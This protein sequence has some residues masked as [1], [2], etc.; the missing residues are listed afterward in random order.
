MLRV[1]E[2]LSHLFY[3]KLCLHCTHRLEAKLLFCASC[4]S[5][6]E[7]LDPAEHCPHC[8]SYQEKKGPCPLCIARKNWKIKV[9][10]VLGREPPVAT[11]RGYVERAGAS[12]LLKGAASFMILQWGRLNWEP[13]DLIVAC[14]RPLWRRIFSGPDPSILLAKELARRLKVPRLTLF[15][16]LKRIGTENR[17]LLFVALSLS[18]L[19]R[20][21]RHIENLPCKRRYFLSIF[22]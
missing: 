14:P 11:Y 20:Y 12:Y 6:F 7:L 13:P 5:S 15:S 21:R 2:L 19:K 3:P 18:D 16:Y 1:G 10:A 17:P 8:F 9:G 4:V 22:G